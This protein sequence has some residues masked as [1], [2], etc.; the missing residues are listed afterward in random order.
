MLVQPKLKTI[1][2]CHVPTIGTPVEVAAIYERAMNKALLE[3][4]RRGNKS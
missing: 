2:T 3:Y 1:W 4:N